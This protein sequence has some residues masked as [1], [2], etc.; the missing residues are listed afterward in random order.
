MTLDQVVHITFHFDP[1]S[2][3]VGTL[4]GFVLSLVIMALVIWNNVR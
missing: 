3:E 2:F 4:V 1:I